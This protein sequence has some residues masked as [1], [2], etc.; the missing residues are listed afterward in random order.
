M[1]TSNC[2]SGH[3]TRN[4][5]SFHPSMKKWLLFLPSGEILIILSHQPLWH[6][7]LFFKN[8]QICHQTCCVSLRTSQLQG[9]V[10]YAVCVTSPEWSVGGA[11]LTASTF[12][13]V[14]TL[15]I[16]AATIGVIGQGVFRYLD[17]CERHVMQMWIWIKTIMQ[18][19]KKKKAFCLSRTDTDGK[20]HLSAHLTDFPLQHT[21]TWPV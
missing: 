15:T 3:K 2:S 8:K 14:S 17:V 9:N 11:N 4:Y 21:Q 19:L 18:N 7:H 10:A 16:Q 12:L 1:E 20:I 13:L 6:R 5:T